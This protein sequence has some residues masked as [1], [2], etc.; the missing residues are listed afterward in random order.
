MLTTVIY[1]LI[2]L[3]L[4]G[5]FSGVEIAFV[6]TN[7]LN[8]ELKRKQGSY[9]GK[10]LSGFMENP[11]LFI[12]TSLVGIN[13]FL[14]I[15][16]LLMTQIT[17][18]WFDAIGL[19]N[20]YLRLL[21]DTFIATIIVLILAEFIPKAIFRA[22]AESL[23]S[24]LTIPIQF[25]FY[26]LYPIAKLFVRISEFILKYIFNVR[27]SEKKTIYSRVDLEQFVKQM[28]TGQDS[29]SQDM[30]TELFEKALYLSQVRV[31][32]CLIPRNEIEAVSLDSPMEEV[33]ALFLETKLSKILVYD[34]SIDN[35]VGY[36][37][38][39]DML[40]EPQSIAPA[41]HNIPAVPEAMSTVDLLNRF[42]KERKSIA[43]VIDEFGGTA[44]IVTMEDILEEIFGEIQ[45]EYDE[46]EYVE[47]QLSATE[48]I[49]S[50]RLEVEYINE[51]YH[52]DIPIDD[53]ETLSGFIIENHESIPKQKERIIVGQY[54]FTIM[55]V[56]DTRIETVKMKTLQPRKKKD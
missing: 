51:K 23:L 20:E 27:I 17:D 11:A 15:Y 2:C 12:G 26:L 40:K 39:L 54:E 24:L 1:I 42:T 8:I 50:G 35:I 4:I 53:A 10:V 14:V 6:S 19:H 55:Q 32:E 45:D 31:R 21:L 56:S 49:F 28:R 46:E 48:F 38:H 22:K 29:E 30:N 47:K 33:K 3:V 25:F 34:G 9:A 13:I 52:L 44:G 43:W 36:L 18:S 16:G 7:K 41:M 5:F 37:H